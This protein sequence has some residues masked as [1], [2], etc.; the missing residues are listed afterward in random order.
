MI[1]DFL[2]YH[3]ENHVCSSEGMKIII[4]L[5]ISFKQEIKMDLLNRF[6][7]YAIQGVD[8]YHQIDTFE[9][10]IHFLGNIIVRNDCRNTNSLTPLFKKMAKYMRSNIDRNIKII[11]ICQ[12]YFYST[13]PNNSIEGFLEVLLSTIDDCIEAY[14]RVSYSQDD[15]VYFFC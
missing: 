15:A 2:K 14:T 11:I 9:S 6:I 5:T 10:A 1:F 13:N 4:S 7:S 12:L 3:M 8:M